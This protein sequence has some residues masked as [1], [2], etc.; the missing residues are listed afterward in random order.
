MCVTYH[1]ICNI[2]LYMHPD[3]NVFPEFSDVV[4]SVG[5]AV[6]V[7]DD[8]RDRPR[9]FGKQRTEFL[10]SVQKRKEKRGKFSCQ[11]K[12]LNFTVNCDVLGNP[13]WLRLLLT[14]LWHENSYSKGLVNTWNL[15][16]A[17]SYMLYKLSQKIYNQCEEN[18]AVYNRYDGTCGRY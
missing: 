8:P 9:S 13:S 14:L 18:K 16:L 5:L 6:A 17:K 10:W 12:F 11:I 1:N 2:K 3:L 4:F 7:R 15:I